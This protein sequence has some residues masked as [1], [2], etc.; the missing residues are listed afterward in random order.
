MD[1]YTDVTKELKKRELDN[2]QEKRNRK[3]YKG[4]GKRRDEEES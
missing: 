4:N 1:I 2:L 3:Q